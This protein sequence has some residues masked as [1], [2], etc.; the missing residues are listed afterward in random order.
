LSVFVEFCSTTGV[1][2]ALCNSTKTRDLWSLVAVGLWALLFLTCSP[3][4][5]LLAAVLLVVCIL[6]CCCPEQSCR[7]G[8]FQAIPKL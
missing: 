1:K 5:S 2:N 8:P 4:G 6:F 7:L 3:R